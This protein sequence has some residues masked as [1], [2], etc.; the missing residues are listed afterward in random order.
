M[1]DQKLVSKF[2]G[3]LLGGAIGDA[4]GYP[5]EFWDDDIIRDHFGDVGIATLSQAAAHDGTPLALISDDTQMTLFT[6]D[7]L[8]DG[9]NSKGKPDR[10]AMHD[11]YMEWLATQ[12][13]EQPSAPRMPMFQVEALHHRRAPGNTCLSAL[14][15]GQIAT[16]ER[17]VNH[18]KG[19]GGVMR[20]A[21][22]G[23]LPLSGHDVAMAGAEAAALT[24]GHPMGFLSA[25]LLALIVHEA[26]YSDCESL[27]ACVANANLQMRRLFSHSGELCDGVDRAMAL[28]AQE[29]IDELEA[30]Y[31][32]G[33]GWV[34]DEALYIAVFC[35][36]R[37]ADDFAGAIRTAVNHEGDSDSTGAIAGNI[38]GAWLGQKALERALDTTCLELRDVILEQADRLL[39]ACSR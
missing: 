34:G 38:L 2:R 37:Y 33:R 4:L 27:A 20:V 31:S 15:S 1:A 23:L 26:T 24:H 30:L 13:G 6:V 25:A 32:L 7:G 18:S 21:P 3:C 8:I 35:A 19:C 14:M 16:M 5:V 22:V 36:L 11:A 10:D 9:L 29:D 28:A 17:P 12:T 39:E